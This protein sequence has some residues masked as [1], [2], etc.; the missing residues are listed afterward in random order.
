MALSIGSSDLSDLNATRRGSP[1]RMLKSRRGEA[2]F[3]ITGLAP[4]FLALPAVRPWA[5]LTETGESAAAEVADN[6]SATAT[7][8]HY[9]RTPALRGEQKKIY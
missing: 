7:A 1:T 3:A 2:R 5:S 6:F 9:T 8:S 4:F